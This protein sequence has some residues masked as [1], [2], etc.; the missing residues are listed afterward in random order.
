MAA[1]TPELGHA[2]LANVVG[3]QSRCT[4]RGGPLPVH[5]VLGVADDAMATDQIA[6]LIRLEESSQRLPEP[7]ADH[8]VH[9]TV[10]LPE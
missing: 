3:G 7:R 9:H 1:V 8:P 5:D 4:R 10:Q 2:L 6:T